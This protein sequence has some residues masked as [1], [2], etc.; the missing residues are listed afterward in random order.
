MISI[1]M[2]LTILGICSVIFAAIWTRPKK[3]NGNL[4]RR[5]FEIWCKGFDKQ[6]T[7]LKGWIEK[8][9][10]DVEYLRQEK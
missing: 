6:W 5:E 2:G 7:D 4:P 1:G 8:I 10:K 3:T 9:Q